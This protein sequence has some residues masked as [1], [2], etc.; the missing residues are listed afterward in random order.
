MIFWLTQAWQHVAYL[1]DDLILF[2]VAHQGLSR[3]LLLYNLFEHFSPIDHLFYWLELHIVPFDP[4]VGTAIAA[5]IMVVMLGSLNWLLRELQVDWLRRAA[6]ILLLGTS[7]VTLVV[8]TWWGQAVY[9]P[10][11]LSLT[12]LIMA[13]HV[14]GQRLSSWRW[15]A[16]ACGFAVL[17]VLISERT[18]FT[19]GYVV[20]LDFAV[21]MR[22]GSLPDA[23]RTL[24]RQR[25]NLVPLFA[26]ALAGAVFIRLFYY[27]A[28]PFPHLSDVA[29]LI[30][31]AYAKWF[32]PSLA[33]FYSQAGVSTGIAASLVIA[34]L[35][36]A[37]WL[38]AVDRANLWPIAFFAIAF[39]VNYAF[40]GIGRLGILTVNAEAGDIQYVAWILPLF[41]IAVAL[42]RLPGRLR[43][44]PHSS[45]L[46]VVLG[47]VISVALLA[48]IARVAHA[49]D[50]FRVRAEGY[51]YWTNLRDGIPRWGSSSAAVLPLGMPIDVAAPFVDPYGRMDVVLPEIQRSIRV[52]LHDPGTSLVAIDDTGRVREAAL[53]PEVALSGQALTA[54]LTPTGGSMRASDGATCFTPAGAG[55]YVTVQLPHVVSGTPLMI[56][57]SYVIGRATSIHFTSVSG[58]RVTLNPVPSLLYPGTHTGVFYLEGKEAAQLQIST[59]EAGLDVC[60]T[61]LQVTT[62]V[63]PEAD[64]LCRTI[65]R[66]AGIGAPTPCTRP[67]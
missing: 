30:G 23:L 55:S 21:A 61:A 63:I 36:L 29:R 39:A 17:G 19:P 65:D 57:L 35:A 47:A 24:W 37:V 4:R 58:S 3:H 67:T 51:Q 7:F 42:L 25:W 60:M 59:V 18:L 5:A 66:Y 11:A 50:A 48:N 26:I 45:W 1:N 44:P 49:S 15:H 54:V 8:T 31:V 12:L 34:S 32:L 40:L 16:A 43:P 14:R 52:G 56:Q 13:A 46:P 41:V 2:N 22:A 9:I 53:R 6:A 20:L 64:G 28:F 27:M 10:V 38:V 62:P 33:G